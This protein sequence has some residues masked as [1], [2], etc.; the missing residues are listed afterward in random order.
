M[1][2]SK[3]VISNSTYDSDDALRTSSSTLSL[4]DFKSGGVLSG[5]S[6]IVF[7]N[8]GRGINFNGYKSSAHATVVEEI[9]KFTLTFSTSNN[10]NIFI[11]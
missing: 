3:L 4:A 2:P 9:S 11:P 7:D 6:L 10:T 1:Y 5:V 8:E